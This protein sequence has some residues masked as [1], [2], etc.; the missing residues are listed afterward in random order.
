MDRNGVLFPYELTPNQEQLPPGAV[1]RL[2]TNAELASIRQQFSTSNQ[3]VCLAPG[4][5]DRVQF[6]EHRLVRRR[7]VLAGHG[8]WRH[9]DATTIVPNGLK[10]FCYTRDGEGLDN[11]VGV[12]IDRLGSAIVPVEVFD[13]G[14]PICDYRLYPPNK[15]GSF[16]FEVDRSGKNL[17]VVQSTQIN[18]LRLS[19]LFR[20]DVFRDADV[21]WSAC[22]GLAR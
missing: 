21:H 16:V 8:A 22:R 6:F 3:A 7:I 17:D 9:G 2:P 19:I 4:L 10:L 18:G 20:Q 1:G 12:Q 15:P 5:R 11:N 14:M 13:A